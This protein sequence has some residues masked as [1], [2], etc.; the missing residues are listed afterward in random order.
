MSQTQTNKPKR[1]LVKTG[2]GTIYLSFYR[3]DCD[4]SNES[5]RHCGFLG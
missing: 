1:F 5:E 4:E 2:A 3:N